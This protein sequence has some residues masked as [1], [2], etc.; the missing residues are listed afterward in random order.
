MNFE[1]KLRH[2]L[3]GNILKFNVLEIFDSNEKEV[4][5]TVFDEKKNLLHF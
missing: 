1:K 2:D 4:C 5:F 3:P